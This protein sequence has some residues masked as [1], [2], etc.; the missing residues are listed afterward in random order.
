MVIVF[1]CRPEN[2]NEIVNAIIEH[3]HQY[4]SD[5]RRY[6]QKI[7][8]VHLSIQSWIIIKVCGVCICD[9]NNLVNV[10][11]KDVDIHNSAIGLFEWNCE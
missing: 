8:M 5:F 6:F 3:I 10:K 7:W 2:I 11:P 4:M 9:T 1:Y